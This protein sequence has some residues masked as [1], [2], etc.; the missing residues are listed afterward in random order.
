MLK[1][2][3]WV[4]FTAIHLYQTFYVTQWVVSS[5]FILTYK[6]HQNCSLIEMTCKWQWNQ[7]KCCTSLKGNWTCFASNHFD[8][9]HA[10]RPKQVLDNSDKHESQVEA[11]FLAA[12]R[13]PAANANWPEHRNSLSLSISLPCWVSVSCS[14]FGLCCTELYHSFLLSTALDDLKQNGYGLK[15][16]RIF[17]ECR[18]GLNIG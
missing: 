11:P 14:L 15:C 1:Q 16:S 18:V 7:L 3:R 12:N 2:L 5:R 6:I 4:K 13:E 8:Y 9:C 10:D 17:C